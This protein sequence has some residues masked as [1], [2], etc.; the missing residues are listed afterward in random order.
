MYRDAAATATPRST[1]RTSSSICLASSHPSAMVTTATGAVAA[2]MPNLIAL[3][4]PGL[5]VLTR[6]FSRGSFRAYSSATGTVVSSGES[7]TT[8]TSHGS[9]TDSNSRSSTLST[10]SPSLYAGTTTETRGRSVIS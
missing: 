9:R 2:S 1:S 7:T 6:H 8:S 4:G 3:A 10:C 5:Y